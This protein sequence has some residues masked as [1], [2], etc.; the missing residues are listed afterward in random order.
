MQQAKLNLMR[1]SAKMPVAHPF[2]SLQVGCIRQ[3]VP[4]KIGKFDK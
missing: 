2:R 3:R 4:L 1:R